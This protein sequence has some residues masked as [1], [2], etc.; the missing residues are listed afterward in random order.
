MRA[1]DWLDRVIRVQAIAQSGLAYTSD[2]YDRE[3]YTQ[4]R[5]ICAEAL[6]LG[7]DEDIER[8]RGLF[9]SEEG[10]ATPKVD[11]RAAAFREGKVLLVRERSDGLWTLPG[12]WAD[13]G[14]TPSQAVLKELREESGFEGRVLKLAA[15]LDRDAQGHPPCPWRIYKLFFICEITGGSASPNLEIVD[16]GFFDP[17]R[18]PPM[19]IN[20]T[21][22]AQVRRMLEHYL[23]PGLPADF[24]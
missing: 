3:R 21:T 11:V 10:Y 12:G 6:A 13:V 20:R 4:I 16:V 18:L 22:P 8:V 23:D 5:E 24:D 15:A 7:A 17:E 1:R 9:T 14:D 2:P 19:S